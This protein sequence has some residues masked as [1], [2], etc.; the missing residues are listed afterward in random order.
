MPTFP[1]MNTRSIAAGWALLMAVASPAFAQTGAP[2][3]AAGS[4]TKTVSKTK[5]KVA[6]TKSKSK[7]SPNRKSGVIITPPGDG[8]NE[9]LGSGGMP[10]SPDAYKSESA[11][12][13]GPAAPTEKDLVDNVLSQADHSTLATALRTAGL[14]E[15][16]KS[17]GPFTVFAPTNAAFNKL[18]AGTLSSLLTPEMKPAL[19]KLLSYHVVPGRVLLASLKN[20]QV[21]TT[22]QGESLTVIK[23]GSSV[24]LQDAKGGVATVTVPNML[25]SNGVTHAINAV[26]QPE[27]Q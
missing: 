18:P 4:K 26:L 12:S 19:T 16:L 17:A 20:G 22:A 25:S 5:T 1:L 14:V 27:K 11:P 24:K 21:L 15:T 9:P 8:G 10:I 6:T 23:S 3:P 13:G 7:G 2:K